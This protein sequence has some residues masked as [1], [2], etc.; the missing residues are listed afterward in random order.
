MHRLRHGLEVH[1]TLAQRHV[2]QRRGAHLAQADV[3]EV[4]LADA[5]GPE[6]AQAGGRVKLPGQYVGRVEVDLHRPVGRQVVHEKQLLIQVEGGLD[7]EGHLG[8]FG[9]LRQFGEYREQPL[10]GGLRLDG[11]LAL[12]GQ[13]HDVGADSPG[14]GHGAADELG[15][16]G[17]AGRI[18]EQQP[19]L[20]HQLQA[21]RGNLQAVGLLQPLDLGRALLREQ[22]LKLLQAGAGNLDA[23]GGCRRRRP[24][25][26]REALGLQRGLRN[27]HGHGAFPTPGSPAR[28]DC[29]PMP[30][31]PG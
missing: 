8:L 15:G 29:T 21:Q 23:V 13:Q 5:L 2:P 16:A 17:D 19:A 11:G 10:E 7:A 28:P 4:D 31:E 24:E 3:V 25:R 14:C 1:V 30:S 22:G 12:E 20:G 27:P 9:L 6:V 18:A 26:T